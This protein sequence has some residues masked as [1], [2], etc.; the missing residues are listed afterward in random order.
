MSL[1]MSKIKICFH[2]SDKID[3]KI[4]LLP[5]YRNKIRR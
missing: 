3:G 4:K 1:T 5:I 2:S